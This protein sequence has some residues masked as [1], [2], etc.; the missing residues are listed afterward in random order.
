MVK[1]YFVFGLPLYEEDDMPM[2]SPSYAGES[3]NALHRMKDRTDQHLHPKHRAGDPT[4]P[5]YRFLDNDE[6]PMKLYV[7]ATSKD[8]FVDEAWTWFRELIT[9]HLLGLNTHVT[10]NKQFESNQFYP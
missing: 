8:T 4:K 6:A 5:I 7:L 3:C 1:L 9:C 2:L 10:A